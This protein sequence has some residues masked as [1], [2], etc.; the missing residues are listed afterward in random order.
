MGI[1][2]QGC[3][4]IV[5]SYCLLHKPQ[6]CLVLDIGIQ[7]RNL[8]KLPLDAY[9]YPRES[10]V[11]SASG[12]GEVRPAEASLDMAKIGVCGIPKCLVL[13]NGPS[14]HVCKSLIQVAFHKDKCIMSPAGNGTMKIG[15]ESVREDN[16]LKDQTMSSVVSIVD[17]AL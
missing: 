3:Y 2:E 11:E 9:P 4:G 14:L 17:L 1:A 10:S 16:A 6:V 15:N 8:P 5:F 12:W 13:D 7:A